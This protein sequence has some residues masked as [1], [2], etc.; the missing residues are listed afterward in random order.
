LG[1]GNWEFGFEKG[2]GRG[3]VQIRNSQ[4]EID[5]DEHHRGDGYGIPTNEMLELVR[6]LVRTEGLLLDPVY[7]GKSFAGLLSDIR[8]GFIEDA[9]PWRAERGASRESTGIAQCGDLSLGAT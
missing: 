8:S 1:I 5:V 9:R 4:S 2:L 3:K 7:G 6:L